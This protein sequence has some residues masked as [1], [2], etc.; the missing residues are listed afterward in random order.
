LNFASNFG[1][2][3]SRQFDA[4]SEDDDASG[5]GS[6]TY[7]MKKLRLIQTQMEHVTNSMVLMCDAVRNCHAMLNDLIQGEVM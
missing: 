2:P 6:E 7:R 3:F 1:I 5:L 4:E